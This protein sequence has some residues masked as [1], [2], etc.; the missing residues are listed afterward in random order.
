MGKTQLIRHVFEQP[1]IKDNCYTFYADIYPTTF[2]DE[3][4][5]KAGRSIAPDALAFAYD[6]FEG[7]TY[8]VHNVLHNAFAYTDSEKTIAKEGKVGSVTSVAFVRKHALK[9][10]SSVQYAISA[11]LEKQLLAMKPSGL[12]RQSAAL[13]VIIKMNLCNQNL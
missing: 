6:L 12:G 4:F 13:A 9:S 7:H 1:F 3:Q 5:T 8:Y 2:A 11:L 10:P